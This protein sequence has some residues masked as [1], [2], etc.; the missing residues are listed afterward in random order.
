MFTNIVIEDGVGFVQD[1]AMGKKGEGMDIQW[2]EIAVGLGHLLVTFNLLAIKYTYEY[3]YIEEIK[4][5]GMM[6]EVVLKSKK[7]RLGVLNHR[8]N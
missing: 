2:E 6:S 3:R 1:L 4:L 5:K 7:K 8:E